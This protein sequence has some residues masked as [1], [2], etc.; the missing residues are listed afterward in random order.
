M[1]TL[2]IIFSSSVCFLF[3]Q[4]VIEPKPTNLEWEKPYPAFRI[5]GNLYYV[6]TYELACYLITTDSGN[7]LINTGLAS[8]AEQIKHNIESLGLRFAET[9]ILLNTQAHF[10]HLGAMASIKKSTKAK[11][12]I[13]AKDSMEVKT[14]GRTDYAIGGLVSSYKPIKVDRYLNDGD[15]IKLGDMA[16]LLLHH[17]GHTKGSCSFL[18]DVND[19]N[20]TYKVLIANM[21]SIIIDQPFSAV[22]SYP[23]IENDYAH[24]LKSLKNLHFDIWLASHASQFDLHKKHQPKDTYNPNAFIDQ[25]GF[26]A[27]MKE[28]QRKFDKKIKEK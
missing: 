23:T 1:S 12:Y 3:G 16:L 7:I 2:I 9:K 11:F 8:S 25:A 18:F 5:V 14:G 24:T 19:G 21:P 28:Y 13:D 15:T 4:K 27:E 6:G 26:D 22:T 17:P 20:K 10:D